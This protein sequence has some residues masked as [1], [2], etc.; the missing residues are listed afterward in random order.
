MQKNIG[1]SMSVAVAVAVTTLLIGAATP[2][3]PSP[4]APSSAG[5]EGP[6]FVD[7]P[8]LITPTVPSPGFN[9][10]TATNAELIANGLPPHPPGQQPNWWIRAVTNNHWAP[11]HFTNLPTHTHVLPATPASPGSE[12]GSTASTEDYANWSG[13]QDYGNSYKSIVAQW[14]VPSV[15]SNTDQNAYSSIWPG[16]GQG[17]SNSAQLFQ[18]GS[19]QDS[20]WQYVL[21]YGYKQY[22]SYTLWWEITAVGGGMYPY[23]QGS[24]VGVSPG[25]T[26]FVNVSYDTGT[27]TAHFY[28]KNDSTGSVQSF[29]VSAP[30]T[31]GGQHAEW[32]FER[33]SINNTL[34]LLAQPTS[35]INITDANVEVGSSWAGVGEWPRTTVNMY[36]LGVDDAE[37]MDAQPAAINSAGNAFGVAWKSYGDVE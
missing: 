12:N 5:P 23:Q 22:L 28:I 3:S 7:G 4:N 2:S 1:L 11:L 20:T 16:L 19:E 21:H 35:A 27:G 9:P 13:Y 17:Y 10:L 24:S 14:V 36:D 25:Q 6:A 26:V 32:I 29:D 30:G 34:P 37:S 8:A 18:A 15:T 33:T 31:F